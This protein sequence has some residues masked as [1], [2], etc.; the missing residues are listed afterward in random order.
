MLDTHPRICI[1]QLDIVLQSNSLQTYTRQLL[2][3]ID[4]VQAVTEPGGGVLAPDGSLQSYS[5]SHFN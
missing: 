5:L 2:L 3:L 1:D 4:A